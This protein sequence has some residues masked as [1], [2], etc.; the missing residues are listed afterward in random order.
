VGGRRYCAGVAEVAIGFRIHTG[1]A[2]AVAVSAEPLIRDRRRI[3]LCDPALPRQAFHAASGLPIEEA[4]QVVARVE[5]SAAEA[6]ERELLGLVQELGGQRHRIRSVAISVAASPVPQE[7]STVLGSH[8][9]LH[10]AEG[11]LYS[12]ALA[13]AAQ[14]AGLPM[15]R[16]TIKGLVA[17]AAA[18]LGCSPTTVGEII[19]KLGQCLGPPWGKDQ[20]DAATAALLALHSVG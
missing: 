1:W 8:P 4:R 3:E 7:L 10:A 16:C 5:R 14:A 13:D 20:K 17:D 15:V 11:Q 12:E 6:A 9:L 2:V 18:A 19:A